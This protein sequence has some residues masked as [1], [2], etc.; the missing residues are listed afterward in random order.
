MLRRE[1]F[2]S[3]R[4]A[5]SERVLAS[6]RAP[7]ALVVGIAMAAV[8]VLVG[9][10]AV[11]GIDGDGDSEAPALRPSE[12]GT[13]TPPT[14]ARPER[15]EDTEAPAP[16]T[17]GAA[18]LGPT[19]RLTAEDADGPDETF[20]RS[21]GAADGLKPGT[22]LRVRVTGF[23]PFAEAEARQCL[24]APRQTC[25]NSIPVQ[26]AA[27]GG[28]FFQYLVTD[29]FA[30]A[31]RDGRCRADAAPC[32]IVVE[33]SNG[34]GRA[35][36]QTVF[37]DTLPPPGRIRVTPRRDLVD[38]Q[39]V[40]VDVEHFP[41]GA[42]VQAMLCG[43]PAAT[44]TARCGEPGPTAPLTVG[45]DG[46]GHTELVVRSGPVGRERLPCRGGEP[47][48]VSVASETLF[49]RA[50][51]VPITF[52]ASPGAAYNPTRLAAVLAGAALLLAV[53][54]WLVRRTDWSPVGEALAPEI[55]D[56]EYADL[57]AIIAALPPEDDEE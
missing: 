14:T 41:P 25:G 10:V 50:P 43:P 55:D 29:D 30:V 6:G 32:S 34:P 13:A 44:G 47:C 7:V 15:A 56:A 18:T 53:A 31:D 20:P 36:L 49:A 48:G 37:H 24:T 45:A 22:V 26:F 2:A 39:T 42:T 38:G 12:P 5:S 40:T 21:Y 33:Q 16:G 52:A 54:T 17:A 28:T 51:V 9:L 11:R 23:E 3:E 27:N 35:E 1:P 57:D 46:T 19:V 8:V 4:Q